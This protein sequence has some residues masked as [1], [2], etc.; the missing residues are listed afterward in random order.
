MITA[1]EYVEMFVIRIRGALA[2]AFAHAGESPGE[3]W[4]MIRGDAEITMRDI[5]AIGHLTGCTMHLSFTP[6]T[7]THQPKPSAAPA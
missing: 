3:Y 2:D 4:P 6:L 7:A 1:E 5:A